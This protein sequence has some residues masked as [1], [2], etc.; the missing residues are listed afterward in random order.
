MQ[1]GSLPEAAHRNTFGD[2]RGEVLCLF[3]EQIPNPRASPPRMPFSLE[4]IYGAHG[5]ALVAFL[6]NVSRNH[7][8]VQNALQGGFLKLA[9]FPSL[10][11]RA[12]EP[13]AL[14]L[15]TALN[16]T[17][18]FLRR[19]TTH[20]AYEEQHGVETPTLFPQAFPGDDEA[21]RQ[22]VEVSRQNLPGKQCAVLHL[23]LWENLT[24]LQIAEAL[25][26]FPRTAARRYRY[27]SDKLRDVL[28]PV[29]EERL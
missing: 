5:D 29:Y 25:D 2:Q 7:A 4:Q 24:F 19:S 17:G 8:L 26:I 23:K 3:F 27:K 1:R 20:A 16:A 21:F 14:L 6:L 28:R 9:R 11:K 13:R 10:F 15:Q 22:T 12:H 18:D